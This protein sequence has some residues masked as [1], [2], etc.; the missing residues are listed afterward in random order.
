VNKSKDQETAYQY[1]EVQTNLQLINTYNV[2]I[3]SPAILELVIKDL[4]LDMTVKE[5]NKK[6]TVQNEKDS[7]VV[8]L[9]VQDTSA[10]T[11]AKI[12]NKT[13]QVFQK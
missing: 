12:A 9:S 5:L 8:N 11:A 6:I 4:H 2:I 10:A 13:A 7:Q 3:K 1:N